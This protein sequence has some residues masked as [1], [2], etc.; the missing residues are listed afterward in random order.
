MRQATID[1]INEDEIA[2]RVRKTAGWRIIG[3]L[4]IIG[5]LWT[6]GNLIGGTICATAFLAVGCIAAGALITPVLWGVP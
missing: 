5:C 2:R 1:R 6:V 3:G 4:L